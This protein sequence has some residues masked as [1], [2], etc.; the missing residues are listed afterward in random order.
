MITIIYLKYLVDLLEIPEKK[1]YLRCFGRVIQCREETQ[2]YELWVELL[3]MLERVDSESLEWLELAT[4]VVKL[5]LMT[6]IGGQ[7]HKSSRYS[8]TALEILFCS[9]LDAYKTVMF[10]M[11][12]QMRWFF[13]IIIFSH[14]RTDWFFIDLIEILME[15]SVRHFWSRISLIFSLISPRPF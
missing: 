1:Y 15:F 14:L 7:P 10:V 6:A 5:P 9:L 12:K 3:E 2:I 11:F 4:A 8:S 13:C